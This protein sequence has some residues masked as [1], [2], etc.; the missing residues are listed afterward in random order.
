[1]ILA[2]TSCTDNVMDGSEL[3]DAAA[4][5]SNNPKSQS[6]ASDYNVSLATDGY[7]FTYT[8]TKNAGA[9]NLG[10]FIVNLDN[11]G[12]ESARLA[13]VLS[14]SV[15][16]DG[17]VT[18]VALQNSEGWGTGCSPTTTNF[19]KFDN[20]PAAAVL[21][22]SFKLESKYGKTS[23]T[24]WL[25]AGTS[26]NATTI[27]APG[28]PIE[29]CVYGIGHFFSNGSAAW[30]QNATLGGHEYTH[31]EGKALF[32]GGYDNNVALK[33]YFRYVAILLSGAL[34]EAPE[35]SIQSIENYFASKPKLTVS[36]L[37]AGTFNS[38]GLN[39]ALDALNDWIDEN[40]CE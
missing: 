35:S 6:S 11:C 1:M 8:I 30:A 12:D 19:V 4:G 13:S 22:L 16:A 33:A 9:K 31:A 28:C 18:D 27:E 37:A 20:L 26:C 29:L 40:K 38:S 34:E 25:K 39:D 5:K 15:D 24:G 17:V 2:L 7:T 14:A 10:H 23:S 21:K 3:S 32:Y 36:G